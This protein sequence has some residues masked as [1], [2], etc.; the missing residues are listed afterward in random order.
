MLMQD[1]KPRKY[2]RVKENLP[3]KGV[4]RPLPWKK[5]FQRGLQV[6]LVLFSA[7][8]VTGGGILG[9][10]LLISSD[11][12]RVS[13]IEVENQQRITAEQIIGLSDIHPGV[14][15]FS[16]DLQL[17]GRK[18]EENPWIAEARVERIYPDEVLIRVRERQVKA[19]INLGYLYYVDDDG[20]IFKLLDP[21]DR[22]DYPALTGLDQKHFLEQPQEARRLLGEAIV[23]LDELARRER[24]NLEEVS[25]LKLHPQDGITLYTLR[26]AVPVQMGFD[27]VSGK[28]DRLEAIYQDLQP[29]LTALRGI[30][31]NVLDRVI[32]KTDRKNNRG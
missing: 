16:L 9:A 11:F 8:L 31:L 12:F 5:I 10:R 6:G 26:G 3:K 19:I 2:S 7:L 17:I 29:R 30:D 22:L 14:S 21:G 28:L 25:E 18:I 32:V 27:H 23:L 4:R 24:F 20:E 15:T 13:I 1:C